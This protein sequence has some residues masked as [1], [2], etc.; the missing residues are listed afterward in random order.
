MFESKQLNEKIKYIYIRCIRTAYETLFWRAN[1]A[2]GISLPCFPSLGA[3]IF[4]ISQ[5]RMCTLNFVLE[6]HELR[7]RWMDVGEKTQSL[8]SGF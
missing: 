5:H 1:N 2:I 6:T 4:D 8:I 7:S 3:S